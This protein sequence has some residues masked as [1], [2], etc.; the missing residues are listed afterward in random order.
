MAQWLDRVKF[1]NGSNGLPSS[2]TNYYNAFTGTAGQTT[3]TLS[4]D[5]WTW[6][7]PVLIHQTRGTGV[8]QWE[9]NWGIVTASTT[10]NF[11]YPLTYTY[12]AGAQIVTIH[13]YTTGT[14]SGTHNV[15][16]WNGTRG[17][18]AALMC[19]GTLTITGTINASAS[20]FLAGVAGTG[21]ANETGARGDGTGANASRAT[22][23]NGNG[24]GGGAPNSA[25]GGGGGGGGG[26]ANAGSNGTGAG[27]GGNSVGNA[28][29]TLLNMG[30]GG[31][32]GGSDDA[33]GYPGMVGG[34]GGGIIVIIAKDIITSSATLSCNASN[35]TNAAGAYR[36]AGGGG[37]G[38]SI[39]IKS[40]TATLGTNR[41]TVSA[42]S[43]GTGDRSGNGGAGSVGRI[44]LDYYSSYTGS[45]TPTL[46][47]AQDLTLKSEVITSMI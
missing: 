40:R 41:L 36:G 10:I 27:T 37:A 17:G 24:G 1:G 12:G 7:A 13:Q 6:N 2:I 20:G 11:R 38:G 44:H 34:K 42:G 31:G 15:A 29:L 28:G 9:L 3:G 35:G 8:G 16:A 18:I 26:H 14:F 22:T 43:G 19:N 46:D 25:D 33:A 5:A 30:G 45:T 4:P 32:G 23:A 39:L 21:A 47:V